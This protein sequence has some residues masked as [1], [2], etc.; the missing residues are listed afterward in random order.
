MF[1]YKAIIRRVV[2]GDTVD[3]LVDCGFGILLK[4][5]FRLFGIDAPETRT[6]DLN[7][8][9]RGIEAK[10]WLEAVLKKATDDK[11][12]IVLKTRKNA[13]GEES[14]G[15]FGRYLATIM[16]NGVDINELMIEC[17]HAVEYKK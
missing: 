12:A 4:Q 6:L 8:K 16:V 14:K 3:F 15:K 13:K 5:R 11:M 17:G 2:D 7:E 9:G 10:L 1:E